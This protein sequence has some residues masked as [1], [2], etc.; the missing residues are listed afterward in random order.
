[1][2]QLNTVYI[3]TMGCQMNEYDSSRI[4][5][6]LAKVYGAKKTDDPLNADLLLLNTCSVR[7]KAK[8]KMLSDLGRWR[9][10]K[11]Q[12]PNLIIGVGGCVASIEG[13]NILKQ[14]SFVDLVFGPQTLHKLPQLINQV[15]QS[16]KQQID[17]AFTAIEKFDN[18][19]APKIDGP[20]AYLSIMEGCNKYCSFCIV[21]YTRGNEISRNFEDV[22][23][24][25]AVLA[26]QG[27]KEITL[28]GQNVN[29]YK[30][31]KS[32]GELVDLAVLLQYIAEIPGIL[33]LR[34][35]TSHPKE[36][37]DNLIMAFKY[38][39]KLAN[40]LHLPIQSGSDLILNKMKRGY[41]VS[42]YLEKI[43]NLMAVRPNIS[44]SSDF[45]VGFPG[46]TEED[47][48]ATLNVIDTVGFDNSYCFIY[49]KRPGTPA[50]NLPDNVSLDEK[51]QRLNIIQSR[52]LRNTL[53]IGERMVN[54]EQTVV[55][56]NISK[57]NPKILCARTENNR[58]VTFMGNHDL[59]GKLI[60]IKIIESLPNSLR[61][62]VGQL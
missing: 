20:S 22:I 61:G 6:L 45:I 57:K 59:V 41:S 15:I 52:I 49:S 17:I 34:F 12:K 3:K 31:K 60:N 42:E 38:I 46:E 19:P 48:A 11:Q 14:A 58:L 4:L 43:N 13:Q 62:I 40:H 10:L 5:D 55:V 28:L 9:L 30:S 39:P 37:S 51:K 32:N 29:A 26:E 16:K 27:V 25:A 21:P 7:E 23:V 35:M 18:L 56:A 54:T 47:F 50:A 8:D 1:M 53:Q 36:F 44:I 33:R 24:E 2:T